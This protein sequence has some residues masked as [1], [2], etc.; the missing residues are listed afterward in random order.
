M[1][2][3]LILMLII[4]YV[5]HFR[6]LGIRRGKVNI[7][8][9]PEHR[10]FWIATSS[11]KADIGEA[12]LSTVLGVKFPWQVKAYDCSTNDNRVQHV[13]LRWKDLGELWIT[14]EDLGDIRAYHI[15]WTAFSDTV[16]LEDCISVHGEIYGGG[17]M[18][19][20]PWPLHKWDIPIH[21]TYVTG[22]GSSMMGPVLQPVWVTSRS[23]AIQVEKEVPLFFAVGNRSVIPQSIKDVYLEPY[24]DDDFDLYYGKEEDNYFCLGAD[25]KKA[26][27]DLQDGAVA[28]LN[29]TLYIGKNMSHS[30]KHVLSNVVEDSCISSVM[31]ETCAMVPN[32]T[33]VNS[34]EPC[35]DYDHSST[36]HEHC[37]T[38][39]R[40]ENCSQPELALLEAPL[41]STF[42][43]LGKSYSSSN[44]TQFA[45][46]I[47][48]LHFPANIL[49]SPGWE[50][51][52][53]DLTFN[54][55]AFTNITQLITYLSD[56]D[57][58]T[59]VTVHPFVGTQS[60]RF[61]E[62][63]D[64]SYFVLD[65]GQR[66]PGLV[67]FTLGNFTEY[68]TV[69]NIVPPASTWWL[70]AL[71]KL[72]TDTGL[73]NF[74]FLGGDLSHL[75]Y[76]AHLDGHYTNPNQY[77]SSYQQF[78]SP[79]GQ[80][81]V[82]SSVFGRT[83]ALT[84][85]KLPDLDSSWRDLQKVVPQVLAASTSGFPF[86]IPSVIGG[87]AANIDP[88]LYIRWAQLSA[89]LPIMHFSTPPSAYDNATQGIVNN[90][91]KLHQREI[92]PVIKRLAQGYDLV[93]PTV[94]APLWYVDQTSSVLKVDEQFLIGDEI[95]VA[96]VVEQGID[97]M[98]I[99]IPK[100]K[101]RD[102]V[103]HLIL[104]G[105]SW[106]EYSVISTSIPYFIHYPEWY[107]CVILTALKLV[108]LK[109]ICCMRIAF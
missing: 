33:A 24:D 36:N 48:N 106:I 18:R 53:G 85:I 72:R 39:V 12:L 10:L 38:Q 89:F 13:C 41:W 92:L 8:V 71:E 49:L 86:L 9:D 31:N 3:L 105:P 40:N 15:H 29:Y 77:T 47:N 64:N 94:I 100:G 95:L 96:P 101:W 51:S 82:T 28:E 80:Q 2:S 6:D 79:F 65:G 22:S 1:F 68:V 20:Q 5:L 103:S 27:F 23:V 78:T 61:K 98:R 60:H 16:V 52:L 32:C 17:V 107:D 104:K 83:P 73:E 55:S 50:A 45:D 81:V 30:L 93:P 37:R 46:Y 25:T 87:T 99:Y 4:V 43:F 11:G 35:V 34:S 91:I 54:P 69:T 57:M 14:F 84:W 74:L 26:P 44:V 58:Q 109:S 21:A 108:V 62:G 97:K 66:A 19:D 102:P 56:L 59:W 63:I 70:S 75:P 90:A 67:P 76:D 7:N 88:E 42:P